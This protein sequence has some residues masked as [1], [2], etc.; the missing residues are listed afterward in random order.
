[1]FILTYSGWEVHGW[2]AYFHNVPVPDSFQTTTFL[3]RVT[4]SSG[5]SY[6][7]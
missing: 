4:H 3:C 1:M 7:S 5:N 2:V 6:E